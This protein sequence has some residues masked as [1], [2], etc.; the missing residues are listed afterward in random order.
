MNIIGVAVPS[1]L[2][3]S[4]S[5]QRASGPSSIC[6]IVKDQTG[7]VMS[8]ATV[9]I[10]GSRRPR[11]GQQRIQTDNFASTIWNLTNMN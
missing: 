5:P 6:G 10:D 11:R 3:L 4:G 7:A 8:A 2:L 1:L 9:G